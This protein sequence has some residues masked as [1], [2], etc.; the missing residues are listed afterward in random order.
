MTAPLAV[1]VFGDPETIAVS[2]LRVGDFV[3]LFPEQGR[4]AGK[5]IASLVEQI[6]E[7]YDSWVSQ[8][9]PRGP[10]M[11]LASRAVSFVARDNRGL[12]VPA[13]CKIVVRRPIKDGGS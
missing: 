7:R 10:K 11:P 8:Y 3:V 12:D 2:E 9:R 13:D 1:P 6:E 4:I 5:N